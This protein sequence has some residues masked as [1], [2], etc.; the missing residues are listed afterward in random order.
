MLHVEHARYLPKRCATCSYVPSVQ[1]PTGGEKSLQ[2]HLRPRPPPLRRNLPEGMPP[3]QRH[4]RHHQTQCTQQVVHQPKWARS[5]DVLAQR[6]KNISF[7]IL[8]SCE[9]PRAG[10]SLRNHAMYKRS[11]KQ[12]LQRQKKVHGVRLDW[13]R[14]PHTRHLI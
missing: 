9:S 13:S 8:V 1:S 4:A 7:H 5:S 2:T 10:R 12:A 3:A 11:P 6:T 14:G